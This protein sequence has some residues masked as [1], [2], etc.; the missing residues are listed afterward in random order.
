[1]SALDKALTI[2]ELMAIAKRRVP[3]QFFDYADSGSWTEG[4][5]APIAKISAK[6]SC[7][8]GWP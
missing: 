3:K 8:S 5:I 6:S 7:A 1:M 2:N 4:P